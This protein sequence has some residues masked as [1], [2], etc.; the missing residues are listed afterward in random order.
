[1]KAETADKI[2]PSSQVGQ[3][4]DDK[5]KRKRKERSKEETIF[6]VDDAC[7]SN[8]DNLPQGNEG[9]NQDIVN[10]CRNTHHAMDICNRP[11][12]ISCIDDATDT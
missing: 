4:Q 10:S 9:N 2:L 3:G 6:T 12:K 11:H 7:I 5:P 8:V 1:R